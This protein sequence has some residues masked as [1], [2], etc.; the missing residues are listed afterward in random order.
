MMQQQQLA[1][2]SADDDVEPDIEHACVK[3][4]PRRRVANHRQ[5]QPS[6]YA[7]RAACLGVQ[8]DRSDVSRTAASNAPL[9]QSWVHV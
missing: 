3:S 8:R 9:K 6:R 7:A 1:P 5:L 4:S 2:M